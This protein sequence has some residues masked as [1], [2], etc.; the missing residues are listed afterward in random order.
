MTDI[1]DPTTPDEATLVRTRLSLH[2]LAELVLAG[3]QRAMSGTIR[4][5]VSPGGFATVAEP[6]LRVVGDRLYAVG[7][8]TGLDGLT[9]AEVASAVGVEA[10]SLAEVYSG[11]L[12]L[13][14]DHV[15]TVDRAAAAV[16]ADALAAGDEAL[17]TLAPSEEPVLW[18]EHLDVAVSLDEVNYGVSAGDGYLATPYAYVGPWDASAWTGEFWNAPFGAARPVSALGGAAEVL[19]F[20]EQ[21][22]SL[23]RR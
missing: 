13:T 23:T 12:G 14:A 17:R 20:F 15:L 3:P 11:G 9:L 21:G 4:L 1:P 19:A 6:S 2:G 7:V 5:R 22:R 10:T 16:V 8:D 18:P